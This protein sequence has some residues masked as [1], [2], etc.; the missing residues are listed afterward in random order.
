MTNRLRKY[1]HHLKELQRATLKKR[2]ALLKRNIKDDEFVKCICE[3]SKNIL[4]GNIP[5]TTLQK[6]SLAKRKNLLRQLS[7]KRTSMKKRRHIIQNGGFLTA[8]LGP[9]ISVLGSIFGGN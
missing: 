1:S 8:L 7:L 9:I 6:K 3:C 5:P 2:K 4:C